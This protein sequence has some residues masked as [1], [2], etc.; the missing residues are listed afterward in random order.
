MENAD[1]TIAPVNA[2]SGSGSIKSVD[3]V[4]EIISTLMDEAESVLKNLT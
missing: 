3:N 4:S 1:L 2:G